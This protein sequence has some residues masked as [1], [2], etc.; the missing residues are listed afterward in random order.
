MVPVSK[1]RDR[2]ATTLMREKYDSDSKTPNTLPKTI[3]DFLGSRQYTNSTTGKHINYNNC[4]CFPTQ[5]LQPGYQL[6]R[7]FKKARFKIG[8][9]VNHLDPEFFLD[10]MPT[11][12]LLPTMTPVHLHNDA[13]FTNPHCNNSLII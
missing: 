2:C 10:S 7:V 3:P 13:L 1:T 4:Q 6:Y 12:K 8:V 11:V 9:T 5:S